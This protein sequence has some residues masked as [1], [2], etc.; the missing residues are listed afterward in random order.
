MP[1]FHLVLFCGKRK[2]NLSNDKTHARRSG[3]I[4]LQVWSTLQSLID[5]EFEI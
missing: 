3:K 4:H 2:L 5:V 1:K